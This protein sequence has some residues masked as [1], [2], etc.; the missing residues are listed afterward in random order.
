MLSYCIPLLGCEEEKR[1]KEESGACSLGE[2][3]TLDFHL[4]QGN[5]V[6]L[7]ARKTVSMKAVTP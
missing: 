4:R 7:R 3:Y 6:F 1:Q 5:P 2:L